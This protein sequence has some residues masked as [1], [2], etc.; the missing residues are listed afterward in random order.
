MTWIT[1]VNS[2]LAHVD[3]NTIAS[4]L[5]RETQGGRAQYVGG[6]SRARGGT[7]PQRAVTAQNSVANCSL[8]EKL[9]LS[10]ELY[11]CVLCVG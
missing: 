9:L 11:V 4:R 2:A 8:K 3:G 1:N 5:R 6:A 7:V 10:G